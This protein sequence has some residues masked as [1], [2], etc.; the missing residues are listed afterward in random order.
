MLLPVIIQHNPTYLGWVIWTVHSREKIFS[1]CYLHAP[2]LPSP[3]PAVAAL[4]A[5]CGPWPRNATRRRP[6]GGRAQGPPSVIAG[7]LG[8]RAASYIATYALGPHLHTIPICI[9]IL[10]WPETGSQSTS[11]CKHFTHRRAVL[12]VPIELA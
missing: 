3:G 6:N 1:Q 11:N 12:E 2:A 10:Q 5:S 9:S 7:A 4:C 8:L